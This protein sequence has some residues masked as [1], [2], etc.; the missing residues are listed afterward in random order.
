MARGNAEGAEM[1]KRGKEGCFS[2]T[3]LS[4]FSAFSAFK[5]GYDISSL[6]IERRTKQARELR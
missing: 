2:S 4:F 1:L 6:R 5:N 3:A